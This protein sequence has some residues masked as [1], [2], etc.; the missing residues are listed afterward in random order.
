MQATTR[1]ITEQ[2]YQPS[3]TE[4]FN[5]QGKAYLKSVMRYRT[6]SSGSSIFE[7]GDQAGKLYWLVRGRV[8]LSK[9]TADGKL[10]TFALYSADDLFGQWTPFMDSRHTM[11][12]EVLEE[13]EIG[14]MDRRELEGMIARHPD[15]A[16][17]MLKWLGWNQVRLE[18]KLRDMMLYGKTGALSS[19]LIRLANTYGMV[20][21]SDICIS[22]K[23]TNT[24]LAE[25]IGSTREGV[26][27]MLSD[28][29]Q[30]GLIAYLNG[31][32]VLK[33]IKALRSL[34]QCDRC[35]VEIC[36]L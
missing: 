20:Y 31:H 35:P 13:A 11:N 1:L 8:K 28:M 5:E 15:F 34:C 30:D 26:N 3:H 16:A 12:A 6:Y 2:P 19:V 24:E 29:K 27:R 36:R 10:V 18:S 9:A 17:M 32:L 23:L 4:I 22:L 21:G 14:V 33:D 25:M 7:D